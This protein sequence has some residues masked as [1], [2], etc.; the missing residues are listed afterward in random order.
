MVRYVGL[1]SIV[2]GFESLRP[3]QLAAARGFRSAPPLAVLLSNWLLPT[4][5]GGGFGDRLAL[6]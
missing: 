1:H 4:S 2:R 6:L 5:S 3:L